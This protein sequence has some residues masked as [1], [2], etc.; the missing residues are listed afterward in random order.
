MK[1]AIAAASALIFALTS[2]CSAPWSKKEAPSE[3]IPPET[4]GAQS[5]PDSVPGDSSG[6]SSEAGEAGSEYLDENGV[7]DT[8]PISEAYLSGDTSALDDFRLEIYEAAVGALES[9]ISD[10]MDDYSKELALHDW[11]IRN[12]TYDKGELRAIPDPGEHASDPYGA[13]I[14]GE[15]ICMGYTTTFKLFMEMIGIPCGI[16]HSVDSDG[17]EHAWNTVQLNGSWY[18]V[19]TTWDD[20]VPDKEGRDVRHLYFN[21]TREEISREHVLPEGSPDTDSTEFLFAEKELM[22]AASTDQITGFVQAAKMKGHSDTA[23]Y[24][25]IEG[26]ELEKEQQSSSI[27]GSD[28]YTFSDEKLYKAVKNACKA[29][30]CEYVSCNLRTTGRGKALLIYFHKK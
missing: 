4:T 13:L 10:N 22:T 17:D 23:V 3:Y 2:G 12:C 30:D 29:A 16:V 14:D 27:S 11:L 26:M 24:F 1:K 15:A 20:P 9:C 21:I 5:L 25:D 28:A 7:F 18:Y 8:A 19:D 6:D